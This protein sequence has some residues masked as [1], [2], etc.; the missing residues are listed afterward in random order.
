MAKKKKDLKVEDVLPN[1]ENTQDQNRVYG[2]QSSLPFHIS[3][4]EV[5]KEDG[6]RFISWFCK[7]ETSLPG[8][9]AAFGYVVDILQVVIENSNKRFAEQE[10]KLSKIKTRDQRAGAL[11]RDITHTQIN[12]AIS[13]RN[14]LLKLMD[15]MLP[16]IWKHAKDNDTKDIK[17]VSPAAAAHEIEQA[18]IISKLEIVKH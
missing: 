14:N 11:K 16:H 15:E 6:K 5:I 4:E 1:P 12:V 7:Y 3:L 18:K 8:Q 9:F 13:T 17:I 10:F 2:L